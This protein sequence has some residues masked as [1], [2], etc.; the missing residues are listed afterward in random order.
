MLIV[1]SSILL[2]EQSLEFVHIAIEIRRYIMGLLE[3]VERL[4][5]LPQHARKP[6]LTDK[7]LDAIRENLNRS[8][9]GMRL[10]DL[11]YF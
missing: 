6:M 2:V 11:H 4:R 8:K 1:I 10:F 3:F 5:A 9:Y 7:E